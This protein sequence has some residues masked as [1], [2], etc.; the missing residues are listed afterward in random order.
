MYL[1]PSRKEKREAKFYNL[2]EQGEFKLENILLYGAE[3][4]LLKKDGFTVQQKKEANRRNLILST[5][6]WD[7][8]F[9]KGIP[10]LVFL[11]IIGEI[12]TF[13]KNLN[14]AQE[15]YVIASRANAENSTNNIE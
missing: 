6:S 10:L 8:P 7:K 14:W 5:V 1:E 13:P 11:Y 3:I 4:R 15:L 12:E 2:A 9:K